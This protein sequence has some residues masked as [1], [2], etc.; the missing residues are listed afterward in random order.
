ML[1]TKGPEIRTGTLEKSLPLK[2]EAGQQLRIT[3]DYTQ[4]GNKTQIACSYE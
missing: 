3:T 2:I 1:D 4:T